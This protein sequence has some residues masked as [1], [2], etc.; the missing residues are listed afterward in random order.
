MGM[1]VLAIALFC[2]D[3]S[4]FIET[5]NKQLKEGYNWSYV[6]PSIPD[7][8]PAILIKPQTTEPYILY[9]LIK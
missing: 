8:S 9:K 7:G 2:G 5:S 6:G 1:L 4:E 3:N